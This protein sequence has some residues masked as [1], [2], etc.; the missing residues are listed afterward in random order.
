MI[1]LT[2]EDK[3]SFSLSS[4]IILVIFYTPNLFLHGMV[5]NLMMIWKMSDYA[6]IEI[7]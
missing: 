5:K 7:L 3:E 4:I 6:I 1:Q 2:I